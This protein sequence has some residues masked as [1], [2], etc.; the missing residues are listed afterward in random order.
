VSRALLLALPICLVACHKQVKTEQEHEADV[1]HERHEDTA[2]QTARDKTREE[3]GSKTTQTETQKGPVTSE[4][5]VTEEEYEP[6]Y[7][8]E[9]DKPLPPRVLK[10]R[11][12]TKTKT[13]SAGSTK[14]QTVG[15]AS[16]AKDV[17]TEKAASTT[18]TDQQDHSK[19]KDREKGETQ[20]DTGPGWKGWLAISLG[21]SIALAT[22][23]VFG[24]KWLKNMPWVRAV[25][26]AVKGILGR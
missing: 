19:T 24:W 2:Q 26:G 25:V 9:P 17:E 14:Q 1:S 13:S 3:E 6:A 7:P 21:A 16:R 22:G 10:H 8:Y 5:E 4:R 20:T 18:K 23:V 11:Q 15:E 12:T